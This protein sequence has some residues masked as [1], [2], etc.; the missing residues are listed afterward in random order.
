MIEFDD[1]PQT[2]RALLLARLELE[3]AQA[4]CT[5]IFGLARNRKQTIREIWQEVCRKTGQPRC[6]MPL[7]LIA[8][9]ER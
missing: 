4:K 1:L 9:Q 7:P 2:S 5:N 3:I 6:T 8:P